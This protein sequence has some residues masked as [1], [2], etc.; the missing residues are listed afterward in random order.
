MHRKNGSTK[1]LG[2]FISE[3]TKEYTWK[4]DRGV[5]YGAAFKELPGKTCLKAILPLSKRFPQNAFIH[6]STRKEPPW[7]HPLPMT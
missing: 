1:P 6:Q 7:L 2:G 4:L 5:V 3:A